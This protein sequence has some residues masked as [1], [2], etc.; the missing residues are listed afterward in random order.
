MV[1]TTQLPTGPVIVERA[2]QPYV[3]IRGTVAMDEIPQIADRMPEVFAWLGERGIEPAG[4]PF[5]R[6]N[7][8]DMAGRLEIEVGVPVASTV[9]TADPVHAGVLPAGRY[10]TVTYVGH[11]SGLLGATAALL[12]WGEKQGVAWDMSETPDG[13]RWGSRLEWYHSD[14]AEVPDMNEWETEL[15][16]RLAD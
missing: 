7:V 16:F 8:I 3:G 4:P 14:P 12:E 10:A 1:M 2:A 6:Y 11:P 9:D 15:A 13:D 5:F